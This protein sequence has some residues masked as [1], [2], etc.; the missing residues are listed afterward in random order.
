ME[1]YDSPASGSATDGEV[2]P[3]CVAGSR[4]R[5]PV[6]YAASRP[7]SGTRILVL[8]GSGYAQLDPVTYASGRVDVAMSSDGRGTSDVGVSSSR[9]RRCGL[10]RDEMSYDPSWTF[11]DVRLCANCF[12]S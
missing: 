8:S 5:A 3:T 12:G 4:A 6:N 1:K 10:V 7:G 2:Y 9:A 11:F